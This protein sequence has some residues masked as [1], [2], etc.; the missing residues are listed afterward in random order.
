MKRVAVVS[1]FPPRHKGGVTTYS[2]N[3][4]SALEKVSSLQGFLAAPR[5]P[6]IS[7]RHRPASTIISLF[8]IFTSLFRFRPDIV[9]VQGHPALLI[10]VLVLRMVRSGP[11]L[12]FTFH[13]DLGRDELSRIQLVGIRWLLE[14][15]DAITFPSSFLLERLRLLLRLGPG[16]ELAVVY[17]GA[18][19]APSSG[20][21]KAEIARLV[22]GR[23]PIMTYVGPMAWPPKVSGLKILLGAVRELRERW[24]SI[25]LLVAGSGPLLEE[26]I[27]Y[28][29]RLGVHDNVRFLGNVTSPEA[30]FEVTD[31][32]VH[33]SLQENLSLAVLEAMSAGLPVIASEV[34]AM[35]EI[36][37]HGQS[38]LL[39][40]PTVES[41]ASSIERVIS[42]NELARSLARGAQLRAK[43]DFSWDKAARA[44]L[45]LC[46]RSN[47]STHSTSS[48][49][50]HN[51][52]N[53]L[54]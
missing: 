25:L 16:F 44:Y 48:Q 54:D 8:A 41:V 36:I 24:P 42:D 52:R 31:V 30:C 28:S 23:S 34:G 39:V 18:S 13:T 5:L 1:P 27:E 20:P 43:D 11:R 21:E 6:P 15:C 17:P 51:Q 35:H 46:H 26:A 47:S 10:P 32:Y 14:R 2:L 29:A 12:V 38:G 7:F 9:L 40:A 19:V 33:I 49:P 3:L 4:L 45:E 37:T 22:S 50:R 53:D